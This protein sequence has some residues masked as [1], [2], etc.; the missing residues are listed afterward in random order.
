VFRL[1][2]LLSLLIFSII[3]IGCGEDKEKNSICPECNM[4][5]MDSKIYTSKI[6]NTYFDDIGCVILWAEKK[7]I[8]L[9]KVDL[10]I[11][12]KDTKKYMPSQGLFF[13]ID[14]QTPMKYGFSAYEKESKGCISFDEVIVRMLRG[15][16]MANPKIRKQILGY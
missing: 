2:S 6:G 12:T 4:P 11:F 5:V 9:K 10:R 13:K 3:I 16:H 14:E 15:E 8:D 1:K 7:G